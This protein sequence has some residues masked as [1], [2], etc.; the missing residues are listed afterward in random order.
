MN[1]E[2]KV[3]VPVGILED[4]LGVVYS[5]AA[6]IFEGMSEI[7]LGDEEELLRSTQAVI[8]AEADR[9]EQAATGKESID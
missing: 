8:D 6:V 7:N 3:E 5:Q 1:M 2:A 4:L 9:Q